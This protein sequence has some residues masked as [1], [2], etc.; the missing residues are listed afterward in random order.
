MKPFLP[1]HLSVSSVTLYARCPAQWRQR[2][3][4]RVTTPDTKPQAWGKA[5][6]RA[7]EALHR[8]DDAEI[9]WLKAW[10][11]ASKLFPPSSFVPGKLHG[12]ELLEAYRSRGLDAARG[13]PERKFQLPFPSSKI[14]VPLLGFIDLAVPDERHYRDFKTTGGSFWTQAKVDLEPQLHAYGWAYQKLYHHRADRAVWVI[15]STA[16][17]TLD[18]YEAT[19]SPDGFRLFERTAEGVWS[20]I[21]AGNYTGC[22][23]CAVCDPKTP[24]DTTSDPSIAWAT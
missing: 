24:R 6:H 2:Y 10:N 4:D 9:A 8:G 5:F 15:F 3:V 20:G 23:T 11:E 14:P 17:P 19:P 18:V 7:L 21:S 13:E 12:L 16:S 22:G 1:R